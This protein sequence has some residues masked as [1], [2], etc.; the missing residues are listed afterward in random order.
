V[1][2]Q[3]LDFIDLP[4]HVKDGGC[5][6][7]AVHEASGRSYVAHTANDALDIIEIE[8]RKYIGSVPELTA[9]ADGLVSKS[10]NL[11]FTSNRGENTVGIF[12]PA[13][14]LAFPALAPQ[15]FQ[16]QAR[17]V[18]GWDTHLPRCSERST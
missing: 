2:L 13:D 12:A 6:H 9:V 5:D 7:A 17:V 18:D 8:A 10:S 1:P 11:G 14:L 15:P 3:H 16:A 4:P